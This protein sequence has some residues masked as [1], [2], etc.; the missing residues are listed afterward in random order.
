[1]HDDKYGTNGGSGRPLLP[2]RFVNINKN[3]KKIVYKK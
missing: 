2:N 1:M 3:E